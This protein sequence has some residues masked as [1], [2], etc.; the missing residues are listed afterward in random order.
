MKRISVPLLFLIASLLSCQQNTEPSDYDVVVYGGTPSGIIAAVSASRNGAQVLLIEQTKH[1]GG[2]ST[3]GLNTAETEHMINNAITGYAR[4]FYIRMGSVLPKGYY[5]RPGRVSNFKL[6]DP[7]FDFESHIA[8][9]VFKEMLKEAKV[10]VVFEEYVDSVRKK[11][12]AI[13]EIVLSSG[14]KVRGK[15]F[16]DA[17]YE[18]DL[19]ARSGVSYTYGRESKD[20]YGESYAG[21]RFMDDTLS[22][23]TVDD[24]GKMLPYFSKNT[25]LKAGAGDKRVMNYNFRPTLTKVENNKVE[26]CKPIDYDSSRFELLGDFLKNYPNT[27]LGQLFGIYPRGSGKFEFNNQQKAVISLGLFGGNTDYPEADYTRRKQ[28][29]NDH[30]SYTLGL[31]YFIGHDQS[32]P[33]ALQQEMLSFGFCKDEFV[34]NGNFPYYLY[35]REARRMVSDFVLSQN[36]I[37]EDRVK[38]D[39]VMLGSHWIDSHHVQRVQISDSTFTNEGR[40]WHKVTKPFEIPYRVLLPKKKECNN[41]LVPVCSSLSHVA[42]CSYRLESTWMQMGHVAGTA[43]ALSLKEKTIPSDLNINS[44]TEQLTLEGVIYKIENFGEYHDYDN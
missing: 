13:Q 33:K 41:L 9:D 40:I 30:K 5:D 43:A 15:V 44:L 3:S 28:I 19:M 27:R 2:L 23:R 38:K 24:Q 10:K 35:I 32:I 26:I 14:L 31:L 8:E 17:T 21:I 11:A 6:G 7:A 22:A 39:A 37:L 34:D 20:T 16:I 29:Y 1:V 12:E 25:G 4:E 36:D 42:Q 18:G